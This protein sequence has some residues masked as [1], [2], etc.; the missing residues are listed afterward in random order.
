MWTLQVVTQQIFAGRFNE[1][2]ELLQRAGGNDAADA[3]LIVLLGKA[4]LR[5]EQFDKAAETLARAREKDPAS[6][7]V[8]FE[9][10]NL[11]MVSGRWNEAADYYR[12]TIRL[13]PDLARRTSSIDPSSS[14]A[15]ARSA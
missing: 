12:E 11:A 6:A 7:P 3:R 13:Q 10:G 8:H 1:A 5:S 2:I 14:S 9:L 15:Y 4:Y